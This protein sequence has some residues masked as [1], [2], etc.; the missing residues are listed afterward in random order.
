MTTSKLYD[1]VVLKSNQRIEAPGSKTF[2]GFST[3]SPD[4]TNFVL[5]DYDL[6]KQDLINH[7]HIRKG[8]KL[9]NPNFGTIIWDMIFEPMTDHSK[10]LIAQDVENI[11]RSDPRIIPN[12]IIISEYDTGLRIDCNLT[13]LP[14]NI[15][16][17]MQLKFDKE[18]GLFASG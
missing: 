1:K 18:N 17:T 16:E 7:F 6:I 4:A 9:E 12:K 5:Y 14:Y 13:I 11:V 10:E 2:K 3:I 8:E 15:T